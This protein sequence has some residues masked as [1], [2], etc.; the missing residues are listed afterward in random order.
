MRTTS[1]IT[2]GI[3][4]CIFV[5][6]ISVWLIALVA[7]QTFGGLIHLFLAMAMTAIPGLIVGLIMLI[8]SVS[9]KPK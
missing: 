3:S 2:L 1:Y 8:V 5:L 6:F 7:G 4:G 9:Q